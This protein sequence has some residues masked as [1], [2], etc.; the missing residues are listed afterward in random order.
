MEKSTSKL[1]LSSFYCITFDYRFP[2]PI[3]NAMKQSAKAQ[4]QYIRG[5]AA[6]R[7]CI[8]F[9]DNSILAVYS[10]LEQILTYLDQTQK[11]LQKEAAE[12]DPQF[13]D[14]TVL[15]YSCFSPVT[16]EACNSIENV[17]MFVFDEVLSKTR[18]VERLLQ[19]A[20][21]SNQSPR[22]FKAML[23]VMQQLNR[24]ISV[25]SVCFPELNRFGESGNKINNAVYEFGLTKDAVA[26]FGNYVRD[27]EEQLP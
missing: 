15:H 27:M 24:L 26:V 19:D 14:A 16:S 23:A 3:K 7:G 12:L 5:Y 25:W 20:L 10:K 21:Q 2:E 11:L 18:A 8:Q 17:K 1:C 6:E 13:A 4:K 22:E 9:G